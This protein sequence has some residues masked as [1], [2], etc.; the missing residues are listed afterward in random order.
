MGQMVT[1]DT[2][3]AVG[4]GSWGHRELF[5]AA[6]PR[7][8]AYKSLLETNG[9]QVLVWKLDVYGTEAEHVEWHLNAESLYTQCMYLTQPLSQQGGHF[10]SKQPILDLKRPVLVSSWR[11]R[12]FS[13][14]NN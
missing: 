5:R 3:R 7:R 13:V 12:P 9:F 8:L 10:T 6:A 2:S 11:S 1:S 4:S 14:G